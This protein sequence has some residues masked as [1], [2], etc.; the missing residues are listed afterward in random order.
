MSD[1][2]NEI[3]TSKKKIAFID[4][5]KLIA[6]FAVII[7]LLLGYFE[8]K[9]SVQQD[10][11]NNF[12][13]LVEK[14]SSDKKEKRLAGA[15]NLGA[16]ILKGEEYYYEAVNILTNAVALESDINVLNAIRGSLKETKPEDIKKVIHRLL[17]IN[18]NY[19]VYEYSLQRLGKLKKLVELKEQIM[20]VSNFIASFLSLTRTNPIDSLVFYQNQMNEVVLT[21]VILKKSYIK[22]CAFGSSNMINA[23]F[24]NSKIINTSFTSSVIDSCNFSFCDIESSLFNQLLTSKGTTFQGSTFNNVFFTGSDLT[25]VDFRGVNGLKPIYFFK[26]YNIDKAIFDKGFKEEV[27]NIKSINDSEFIN[28]V[29]NSTL[30]I[31]SIDNLFITL[32]EISGER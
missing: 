4:I 13:D 26:A 16:F 23:N 17:D 15:T 19:F 7:P 27:E 5:V 8:Y 21:D 20:F 29:K 24:S 12:R 18:R 28:Y 2:G 3:E 25:G 30:T 6:A 31:G 1:N 9:R 32:K 22:Y 14:L 10:I 11:D